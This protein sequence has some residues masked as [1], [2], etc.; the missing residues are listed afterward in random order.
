MS[1]DPRSSA[2]Q[3]VEIDGRKVKL[4]NLDKVL[5][6]ETGFTKGEVLDY[7]ARIAPA[8]LPHLADRPATLIR[9]P[10]GV[11]AA[12]FFAK[13]AP[14]HRPDW[15]RTA[16]IA[17]TSSGKHV[18]Y[19]LIDDLSSLMWAANLAAIEF[20]VPQWHA[21]DPAHHDLLVL[22]LDPGAPATVLDCVTVAFA[23]R[24]L[25]A[26]HGME[27]IAKTSGGKGLH[28]YAPLSRVPAAQARELARTIALG[29]EARLPELVVSNMAKRE[30]PGKVFLDWSQNTHAKT[31]VAP[32]S[33][34]ARPRPTVSTPVTWE[35][36]AAAGV[37][38]DLVFGPPAA[39]A[40]VAEHGDLL[41]AL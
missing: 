16:S 24:E 26:S 38:E 21:A 31:T 13:H 28:L 17:A 33:L 3:T 35:Q 23:A 5:F 41:S 27:L 15:V 11:D 7:Y 39:L 2:A 25:L 14:A 36:L 8:M 22:D 9:H 29:L 18:E 20:H 37:P 30:R 6:P 1:P 10:D 19:L 4:T 34:R 40:Q 12:G 32:Y